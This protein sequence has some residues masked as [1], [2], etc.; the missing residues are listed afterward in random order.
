MK[1]FLVTTCSLPLL[2][3]EKCQAFK[4]AP[5]QEA[6]FVR[7]YA[8]RIVISSSNLAALLPIPVT[9]YKGY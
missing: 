6:A 9:I 3:I 7:Q 8:G 4:V 2:G 1:V 5:A